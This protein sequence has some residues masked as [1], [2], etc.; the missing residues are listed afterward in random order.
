M[1]VGIGEKSK[2][3]LFREFGSVKRIKEAPLEHLQ[4]IIGK[5]KGQILYNFLHPEKTIRPTM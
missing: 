3:L 1:A 4:T 2:T 5:A